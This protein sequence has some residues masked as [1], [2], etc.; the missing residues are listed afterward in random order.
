MENEKVSWEKVYKT[1][2]VI[3]IATL[4]SQIVFPAFVLAG[5]PNL[6][7]LDLSGLILGSNATFVLALA[8]VSILS[9]TLSFVLKKKFL[10]QAIAETKP[11]LFITATI[12]SVA[13][14]EVS[15]LIGL[16]LALAFNYQFFFVFS[17]LGIIGTVLHFPKGDEDNSAGFKP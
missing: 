9:L 10:A 4:M 6:L 5:K 11:S 15:S 8:A 14:A 17:A 16:L 2:Q 3:W 13:L 1:S 7:R 12:V